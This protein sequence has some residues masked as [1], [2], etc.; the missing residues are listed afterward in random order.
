MTDRKQHHS[1]AGV[2]VFLLLGLFAVMS[3]LLVLESA[4]AYRGIVD[5]TAR[6]NDQRI[7]HAYIRNAVS[8]EDC[9]GMVT[10][11]E[12]NGLQVLT[13]GTP[14]A[15][16]GEADYVKYIYCYQGTLRDQFASTAYPFEPGNGEEICAV[17][18]LDMTQDGQLLCLTMTDPAG[19]TYSECIALR[20]PVGE[21]NAR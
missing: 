20:T 13:I 17:E 3:M 5:A 15:V 6:H 12:L 7:I 10:L 18:R 19:G 14:R 4:Q 8:A 21:V 9:A 11:Q 1:I 16:D 2:F